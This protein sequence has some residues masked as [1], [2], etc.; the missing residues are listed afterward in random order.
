MPLKYG[1]IQGH[2][3]WHHS[4]DRLGV[5]DGGGDMGHPSVRLAV[6]YTC[7]VYFFSAHRDFLSASLYVSKRGAY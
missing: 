4:I 5:E 6:V 1:F 7:S 2:W 3:K